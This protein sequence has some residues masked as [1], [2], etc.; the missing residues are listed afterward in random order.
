MRH[1]LLFLCLVISCVA[2]A[3]S[4]FERYFKDATLRADYIFA[5]TGKSQD[6]AVDGLYSFDGWAGRRFRLD[7]QP[8]EGDGSITM[9]DVEN[10]KIIYRHAFSTL[11]QEWQT[12]EEAS[13]MR[14][15]FENVFL[16]PFPRRE[17]EITVTLFDSRR[18][19]S[20]S[21]THRVRPD[22]ILIRP[23]LP[24]NRIPQ[25]YTHRGGD[26]KTCIDVAIV[27]EGYTAAEQERFFADA[28]AATREILKY[29][30]F[31][32]CRDRFNFVAV[33]LESPES[34]VSVPHDKVWKNTALA[35]HFDTFY[36]RRYLTTSQIKTLHNAL[37]G[38]PYEHIIILANTADYGGGGIYNS[39]VLSAA[40]NEHFLPVTVHEFGHSFGGLADEYF[41]DDQ[42]VNFYHPDVEPRE[43]NI[44]T[45]RDFSA[46]WEDLLPPSTPIPTPVKGL[47]DED[48]LHIGVYEGGGYMSKGV[49]RAF[50]NCRMRTNEVPE[51]CRVCRRAIRRVIDFYTEPED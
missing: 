7:S 16:L 12:T 29:Q 11:F 17:T 9:R 46:K 51:F 38:I 32:A 34:G 13:H 31:A 48:T 41:Y 25:R 33:A 6:I 47:S 21:Y 36:S 42:Y 37:A 15:S 45:L 49:Y 24:A 4:D 30:P 19:I 27:A 18:Q 35:S 3:Q 43:Q 22:D 10:G 40:H 1:F 20:C 28:Q 2:Q 5:G 44:T 26:S 50:I 14:K 8:P 23:L 39:Y